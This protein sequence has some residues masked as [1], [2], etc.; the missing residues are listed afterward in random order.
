M[1]FENL[2]GWCKW[3]ENNF[4]PERMIPKLPVIIRLDGVGF[5][6]WT[7]G[8]EK[9]FDDG[10]IDLMTETTKFLVHETNAVVGYTFSDEITLILYSSSRDS[11]IY[12]TGRKQ[13]ILS[14]LT[15]KCVQFFNE[16]RPKFLPNHNK[17]ANFDCRIYQAPTLED[18]VAQVLWR[19]ND[20]SKNSV[21]MLAQSLFSHKD[22]Q[23]M[24]TGQLQD[25]MMLEKGVN[26]NDLASKYK[27]GVYVRRTVTSK[28][29][30]QEELASLP[31]K[32]K[33]HKDPNLVI[34]RSKVDVVEFP[35]MQ[36]I[37]NR[38][39]VIFHGEEPI[40]A[41]KERLDVEAELVRILNEE[42]QKVYEKE[43]S[44]LKL[45]NESV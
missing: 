2:S 23:N 15:G 9:P 17:V 26:W 19:E 42:L 8:L 7:K 45:S 35:I 34:E 39:G 14:K 31:P 11:E 33:A 44:C 25:K 13:K 12:H 20:A 5:S 36:K 30:S 37:G 27:R 1:N 18:A 4:S 10:L 3:L 29:F 28:P 40:L 32:H 24:H 22:L 6:K 16:Q 21:S 43:N 38:V 41:S